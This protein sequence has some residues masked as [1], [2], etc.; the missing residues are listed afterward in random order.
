MGLAALL[1]V[2]CVDNDPTGVDWR[3]GTAFTLESVNGRALP[4]VY[5]VGDYTSWEIVADT[6]VLR[7]DGTGT[8]VA[9]SR[10]V[11]PNVPAGQANRIVTDFTYTL[12]QDRLEI[13]LECNDVVLLARAASCV[14][15]PHFA[16][17]LSSDGITFDIALSY[18]TPARF[19]RILR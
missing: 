7:P 2:A 12:A 6:M 17:T 15:P 8:H 3:N 4:A 19:T 11:Y 18:P 9:I 1:L 14:A 5:I 10:P 16:G 13:T